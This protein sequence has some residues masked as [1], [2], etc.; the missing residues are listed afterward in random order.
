MTFDFAPFILLIEFI[1]VHVT[2]SD[3]PDVLSGSSFEL[4]VD[5]FVSLLLLFRINVGC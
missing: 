5:M 1:F 3:F 2:L 4:N